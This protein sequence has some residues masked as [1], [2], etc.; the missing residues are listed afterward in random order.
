M[1]TTGDFAF[2]SH[3]HAVAEGGV[4][5]GNCEPKTRSRLSAATAHAPA[6]GRLRTA[7]FPADPQDGGHGRPTASLALRW[8]DD[9][10][11]P[12][13]KLRT[14][15]PIT[16]RA[17]NPLSRSVLHSVRRE[18]APR[19]QPHGNPGRLREAQGCRIAHSARA[20]GGRFREGCCFP[21]S[22]CCCPNLRE[23]TAHF[24]IAPLQSRPPRQTLRPPRKL[25][26]Y[27][28]PPACM[29]PTLR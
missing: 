19:A 20:W 25:S 23:R 17:S 14:A 29:F 13:S 18:F 2:P 6:A 12:I 27:R 26:A 28:S 9:A 10:G 15:R 24:P 16:Q 4:G 11:R 22:L 21:L 7:T 3:R 1:S 5:H 8:R